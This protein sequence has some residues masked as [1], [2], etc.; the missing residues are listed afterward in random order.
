MAHFVSSH[1][2][3]IFAIDTSS[4]QSYRRHITYTRITKSGGRQYLQL[5]ESFRNDS[6]KV[7]TRVIA[8]FG[9]LD[10]ITPEKIDPLINGLNRAVGRAENTSSNII[11]EPGL[12][13][14]DVFAL[15]E[16]WRDLGIDVALKRA[17]RSSR[18]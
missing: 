14:G 8:N 17:L 9:R 11:H 18:R 12:S 3:C 15:R 2:V 13:F 7:R 5:V 16:L 1:V 6:G 10:Q 4:F